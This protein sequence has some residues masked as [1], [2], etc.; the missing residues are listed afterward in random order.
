MRLFSIGLVLLFC[1]CLIYAQTAEDTSDKTH[2][3]QTKSSNV[4]DSTVQQSSPQKQITQ[5]KQDAPYDA[6]KDCLYLAYLFAT[7]FGVFVA[8]G[9]IFAIYKQTK[10]TAQSAKATEK[11]V[12]LQEIALRQWVNTRKWKTEL[13]EPDQHPERFKIHFEIIN[14]TNAPII[15]QWAVITTPKGETLVTGFPKD[16]M[17]IPHKPF[18]VSVE[19]DLSVAEQAS[20][21]SRHGLVLHIMGAIRYIDAL[22]DEWE[23]RFNLELGCSLVQT[24]TSQYVHTLHSIKS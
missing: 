15:L 20:L 19:R 16:A 17:L 9:G 6:S 23:Q 2:S 22:G 3:E 21:H 12:K 18:N 11:S 24:W 14:P 8:L 1:A 13:L 10:A 7:I 5:S 4:P